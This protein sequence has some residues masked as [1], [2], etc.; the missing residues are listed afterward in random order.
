M[1]NFS[2]LSMSA[3]QPS[4]SL[5]SENSPSGPLVLKERDPGGGYSLMLL[6]GYCATVGIMTKSS[7]SSPT[8][9]VAETTTASASA[10]QRKP[11]LPSEL[12]RGPQQLPGPPVPA[13]F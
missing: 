12:V 5:V 2:L 10:Q 11:F 6:E 8:A 1:Y 4:P 3:E 13:C 9:S 7:R